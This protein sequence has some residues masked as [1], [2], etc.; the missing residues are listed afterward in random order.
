MRIEILGSGHR[1]IVLGARFYDQQQQGLGRYFADYIYSELE[2]LV[3][4]AGVHVQY[5]S[6]Y[7]MILKRFPYSVYYKI[8]DG[9]VKVWRILDNRR[10]PS[11]IDDQL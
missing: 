2:S 10:N 11:W 4:Y 3:V 8:E 5:A 6:Y 9:C 1:D 7:K